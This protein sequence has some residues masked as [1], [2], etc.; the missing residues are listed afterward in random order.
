MTLRAPYRGPA[1]GL[2]AD[3]PVQADRM[4]MFRS[5]TM[6]KHWRYVSFWGEEA[7]VCVARAHFGPFFQEFWGVWDR[8]EQRLWERTRIFPRAV[9]LSPGRVAVRERDV[10]I[11]ITLEENEGFHTLTHLGPNQYTW[12]RKQMVPATA[13]LAMGGREP[14][15]VTARALIDDNAG[16]HNRQTVWWWSGG[17][18]V[19]N[20]GRQIDW[21]LIIGLNDSEKG[22]ERTLWID[23][24]PHEVGPVT[25]ADD[26]SE[27]RFAEGGSLRFTGE[28]ERARR[29]NWVVFKTDYR[30]PFGR[31]QGTLPDGAEIHAGL[32]VMEYHVALW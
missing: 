19:D 12:T 24:V 4:P 10:Q 21:N 15:T 18:G 1:T 5:G 7:M 28:A 13:R 11:D 31:F 26:L 8:K 3:V 16:Y 29:E 20:R 23:G 6:R 32:G 27:V 25:F 2:P 14:V 9:S 22:S 17:T 30:Q